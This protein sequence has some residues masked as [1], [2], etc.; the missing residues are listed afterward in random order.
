M[1][2]YVVYD[3][4]CLLDSEDTCVDDFKWFANV[5]V[6]GLQDIYGIVGMSTGFSKMT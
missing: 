2:G 1:E 6:R 4:V 3:T 5:F